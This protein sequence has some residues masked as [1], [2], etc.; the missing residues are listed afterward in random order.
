MVIAMCLLALFCVLAGVGANLVAPHLL[1]IAQSLSSQQ[2]LAVAQGATLMPG[3]AQQAVLTPSVVFLLLI[4]MPILPGL[5]W[6]INRHTVAT[7]GAP[8]MHGHAAMPGKKGW[9]RLPAALRSPCAWYLARF[10]A[11]VNSSILPSRY[12]AAWGRNYCCHP[13]RAVL[14][15][16]NHPAAG[17]DNQTHCP[18][19]AVS[20][21]RRFPSLLPVCDRRAGDPAADYRRL[22]RREDDT[23]NP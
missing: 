16:Q 5:F 15:R 1:H 10:I 8:V 22:R 7:S 11:C 4:A 9:P 18:C 17:R 20:A 13:H 6:Y 12:S 3:D 21:K 14:G 19:G 23:T 2:T